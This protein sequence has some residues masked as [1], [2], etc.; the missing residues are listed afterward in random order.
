MLNI[1]GGPYYVRDSCVLDHPAT[2]SIRITAMN[3]GSLLQ[4]VAGCE[5]AICFSQ[6]SYKKSLRV[7]STPNISH[8]PLFCVKFSGQCHAT[9]LRTVLVCIYYL[10]YG[11]KVYMKCIAA[12]TNRSGKKRSGFPTFRI[13]PHHFSV[14]FHFLHPFQHPKI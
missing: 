13:P 14:D 4:A 11:R 7:M 10:N 2:Q 9:T 1:A 3:V 5:S 6:V 12:V 8:F